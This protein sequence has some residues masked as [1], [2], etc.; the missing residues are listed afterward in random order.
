MTPAAAYGTD[1]DSSDRTTATAQLDFVDREK[2]DTPSGWKL[3]MLSS[4]KVIGEKM[5]SIRISRRDKSLPIKRPS[6]K[7]RPVP[8]WDRALKSFMGWL[9]DDIIIS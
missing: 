9:T 6:Q 2:F 4:E 1:W 8:L 3:G 5:I 7:E